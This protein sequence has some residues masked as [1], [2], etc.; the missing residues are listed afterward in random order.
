MTVTTKGQAPRGLVRLAH[1]SR[2]SPTLSAFRLFFSAGW[3]SVIKEEEANFW[4]CCERRKRYHT[5]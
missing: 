2:S 5:K 4:W 1:S 3:S